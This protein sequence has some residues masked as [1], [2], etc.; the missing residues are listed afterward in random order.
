MEPAPT[1]QPPTQPKR[2]LS[3]DAL[4]KLAIAREKA[5]AAR[6]ANCAARREEKAKAVETKAEAK[7]EA[8]VE[9]KIEAKVEAKIEPPR[10]E[11]Q[12]AFPPRPQ[13]APKKKRRQKIVFYS[14]SSES[15]DEP[16]IMIR[17]KKRVKTPRAPRQPAQEVV[18]AEPA[19]E[20]PP[21]RPNVPQWWNF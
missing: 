11:A 3:E 18:E 4:A 17:T 9:A 10:A 20:M 8:K 2:V 12:R 14:S 21:A 19:Q 6:K 7:V 1:D 13:S 15:D 5:I 16:A